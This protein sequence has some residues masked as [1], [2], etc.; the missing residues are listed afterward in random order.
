MKTI[1]GKIGFLGASPARIVR[2]GLLAAA[3][4]LSSKMATPASAQNLGAYVN[5]R[6]YVLQVGSLTNVQTAAPVYFTNFLNYSGFHRVGFWLTT[7][8]T[9]AAGA[10]SNAVVNI[11]PSAG[12]GNGYTNISGTNVVWASTPALSWT[13]AVSALSTNVV[14]TNLDWQAADSV[15]YFKV[16]VSTTSTNALQYFFQVDGV[17][18]P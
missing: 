8:N 1:F 9:N 13:N 10:Y 14:Y 17:I 2:L 15:A 12:S 11:Y 5:P 16:V 3:I 18:T 6:P 4:S 7:V